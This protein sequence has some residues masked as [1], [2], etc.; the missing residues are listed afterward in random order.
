VVSFSEKESN[1]GI[2]ST[3]LAGGSGC[4]EGIDSVSADGAI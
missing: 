3:H 4:A 1:I 2:F